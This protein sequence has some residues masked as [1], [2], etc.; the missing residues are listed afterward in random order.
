MHKNVIDRWFMS[1]IYNNEWDKDNRPDVRRS[2]M[3]KAHGG[4]LLESAQAMRYI[5]NTQQ[6]KT[7]KREA[8]LDAEYFFKEHQSTKAKFGEKYVPYLPYVR[9]D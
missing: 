4:N 6:D 5:A 7:A 1:K 2:L 3:L 8:A 9:G